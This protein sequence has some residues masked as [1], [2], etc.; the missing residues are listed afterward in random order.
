M[1]KIINKGISKIVAVIVIVLLASSF[2]KMMSDE[3][4]YTAFGGLMGTLPFA[5]QITDCLLYTSP[6]PRD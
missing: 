6:S 3:E 4:F 1:S 2:R 5:K